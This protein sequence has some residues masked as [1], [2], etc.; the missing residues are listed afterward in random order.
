MWMERNIADLIWF[1]GDSLAKTSQLQVNKKALPK[2]READYGLSYFVLLATL[3]H[4]LCCWKMSG[5]YSMWEAQPSLPNLPKSG[6]VVSG[7]LYELPTLTHR[8]KENVGSALRFPTPT[9]SDAGL[10]AIIGEEDQYYVTSTGMPRKV[11]KNGKDGSVGLARLVQTEWRNPDDYESATLNW[12]TPKES[13]AAHKHELAERKRN[14]PRL[15][16]Q[17]TINVGD[18]LNPDWV[19]LLLGFPTGWT[20][21]EDNSQRDQTSNNTN[22]SHQE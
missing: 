9:A 11:N 15:P 5:T 10:G 20:D 19:E 13:D 8:I 18:K 17:A 21:I 12:A 3:D 16:T 4:E 7:K 22:T 14:S 1:L 2:K 6:I